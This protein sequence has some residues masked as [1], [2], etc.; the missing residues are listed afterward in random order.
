MELLALNASIVSP[1][2]AC[3][4]RSA[5]VAASSS[6]LPH[7]L[8]CF[9][10]PQQQPGR[11]GRELGGG[12]LLKNLKFSHQLQFR[13]GRQRQQR[14][15]RSRRMIVCCEAAPDFDDA[16]KTQS[17]QLYW[18]D[19]KGAWVLQPS[20][21]NPVAVVHFI[22]GVF[23]GATPQL[24]YRLFL[25]RLCERGFI[26]IAT[27]FASG[28]DHLRIADETQ[29]K[30]DR[31]IRSLRDDLVNQ[32]SMFGP[33]VDTLPIFGVGHSFGALAQLLIGARYA[34]QRKGNV[35]L[36][37]NNKSATS[38]I[39]LL[40]PVLG[41]VAQ[42]FS[43]ILAQLTAS[44]TLC[45]GVNATTCCL[46]VLPPIVKQ[47][48]PLIEQLPPLYVDLANGKDQFVPTPDET[49]RLVSMS[50][51]LDLNLLIKFK[52]DQIDETP[53][54]AQTLSSNSAVSGF[55][56]MSVRVL[57]GD[58]ARP[59]LQVFPV[60][61]PNMA[62]TINRGSERSSTMAAGTPSAEIA[63]GLR[64]NPTAQRLREEVIENIESL[65]DEIASWMTASA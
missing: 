20:K 53:R 64:S 40:S 65:I 35:L 52:D 19:R 11:G 47:V 6:W 28:F 43:P 62:R 1:L 44:P 24:S 14:R 8:E 58:H 2:D 3:S 57:P 32:H 29:F 59:L 18:P 48:L 34:V 26:V 10:S 5:R 50:K 16:K 49:D 56:D 51:S 54:L 12:V 22:G 61:P 41:P 30:F 36:S 13:G 15:L 45:L 42:N 23:V 4:S 63:K 9:R 60:V 21:R 31:C 46:A 25:E 37:F 33:S 27:P 38:A 55:L 7:E 17:A 39:P